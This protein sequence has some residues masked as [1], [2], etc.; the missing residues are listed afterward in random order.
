MLPRSRKL[1]GYLNGPGE[2]MHYLYAKF[3]GAF[4]TTSAMGKTDLEHIHPGYIESRF[5]ADFDSY[6]ERTTSVWQLGE[7][8]K[9]KKYFL[10]CFEFDL[11]G[12]K[13]ESTV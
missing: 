4:S 3:G 10:Q 1:G 7:G 5:E 6:F 9:I 12:H 8:K 11:S 2:S 13:T